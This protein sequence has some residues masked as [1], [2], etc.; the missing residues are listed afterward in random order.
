VGRWD[1]SGHA[2]M[3]VPGRYLLGVAVG[4]YCVIE[5]AKGVGSALGSALRIPGFGGRLQSG[6]CGRGAGGVLDGGVVVGTGGPLGRGTGKVL[7]SWRWGGDVVRGCRARVGLG[8]AF[9]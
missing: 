9:S 8:S 4:G 6:S 3:G 7:G 1:A 5:N 2:L